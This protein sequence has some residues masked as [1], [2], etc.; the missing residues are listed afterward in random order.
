VP[1]RTNKTITRLINDDTDSLVHSIGSSSD[2]NIN[3]SL[4]SGVLTH[5][6]RDITRKDIASSI[7]SHSNHSNISKRE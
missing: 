3:G 1:W 6:G 2:E 4:Y 7:H 5:M